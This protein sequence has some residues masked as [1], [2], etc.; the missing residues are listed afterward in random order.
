MFFIRLTNTAGRNRFL[1]GPQQACLEGG[2]WC[3]KSSLLWSMI[4]VVP[5]CPGVG[6]T[7]LLKQASTTSVG[8]G[9]QYALHL[10]PARR[11]CHRQ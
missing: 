9:L 7:Q 11:R 10:R 3:L 2:V 8:R 6:L 1:P 5:N 4:S